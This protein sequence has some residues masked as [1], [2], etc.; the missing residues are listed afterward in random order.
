MNAPVTDPTTSTDLSAAGSEVMPAPEVVEEFDAQGRRVLR[1]TL[2]DGVPD[3]LF[4]Q[5]DPDSG[6]RFQARF[7]Q[8]QMEGPMSL[9]DASG[10]L[11]Q[12]C[13]YRAGRLH[14]TMKTFEHGRCISQQQYVR[15]QLHGLSVAFDEAGRPS[16]QLHYVA[17]VLEGPAEYFHEGRCTRRA[18]YHEDRL[19]GESV[20]FTATGEVAQT[21]TYR[22]DLLHGPLR[23]FWPGGALM[24]EIVYDQG[25]PVGA[26]V[27]RDAEGRDLDTAAERPSLGDRLQRLVRGG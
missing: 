18:H 15:G 16:A 10:A 25:V 5:I 21:C 3:G 20:D 6:S 17:G 23:R 9:H 14:G 7:R 4:E 19:E 27:R 13:G 26:P 8:G 22:A 1:C 2:V 12:S 24:E 11:V